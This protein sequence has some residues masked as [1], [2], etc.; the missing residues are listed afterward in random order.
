MAADDLG[1]EF[2][3][4]VFYGQFEAAV[5][6]CRYYEGIAHAGEYVTLVREP[7][8]PYDPNAVRVDNFDGKQATSSAAPPRRCAGFWTIPRPGGRGWRPRS[9]EI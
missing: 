2:S 7:N 6:G 8:N 3:R 1:D 5:V 4:E 9:R